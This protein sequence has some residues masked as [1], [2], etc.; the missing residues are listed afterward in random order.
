MTPVSDT[1]YWVKNS[2]AIAGAIVATACMVA[3]P[4]PMAPALSLV[5][6]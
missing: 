5:P 6:A 2:P 1:T 4:K 3:P